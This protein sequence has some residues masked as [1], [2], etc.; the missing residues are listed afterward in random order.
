MCSPPPYVVRYQHTYMLQAHTINELMLRVPFLRDVL[1]CVWRRRHLLAL[2]WLVQKAAKTREHSHSH[3]HQSHRMFNIRALYCSLMVI[4]NSLPRYERIIHFVFTSQ[5]AL[6]RTHI[7][8]ERKEKTCNTKIKLIYAH[9]Q[10]GS[11]GNHKSNTKCLILVIYLLIAFCGGKF[12]YSL[13]VHVFRS[14]RHV[15]PVSHVLCP[16]Q[17]LCFL[18]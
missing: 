7:V 16:A 13:L 2:C 1:V 17:F 6:G 9:T 18:C 12:T 11:C 5:H 14:N 4:I 8:K 15:S 3:V 10:T